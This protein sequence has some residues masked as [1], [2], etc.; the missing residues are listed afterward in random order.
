MR[1]PL[2]EVCVEG[3]DGVI[4]AQNGGADRAE[5]CAS[6][7][8][9][10]I[11]PSIGTVRTAQRRATIPLHVM[12]R[13]RGGDF[14]YSDAEFEAMLE[15]VAAL[16]AL[17]VAGLVFGCLLPDATVDA[18]RTRALVAAA[19]PL[20]ITFHRAFDQVHNTDAALDCLIDCGVHRVLTSGGH[21]TAL[22]GLDSLRA[23]HERA[24]GRI[25]VLGC[26]S[27]RPPTIGTVWRGTGL[28]ELHFAAPDPQ[29]GHIITNPAL[30]QATIAACLAS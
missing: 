22:E 28:T 11:T 4:A 10:G 18:N 17:G 29:A 16:R 23:L 13:P 2:F 27:L 19:G 15:D 20:N 12:V 9:G 21:P 14:V 3:P 5:L 7:L 8:E 25:I 26:G 30:V 1:R 24:A 6:L